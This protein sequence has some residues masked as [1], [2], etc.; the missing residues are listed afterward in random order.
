MIIAPQP[1]VT[2]RSVLAIAVPIMLSNVT[3]PLIGVVNT[4]VIGQLPQAYYI[5]AIAVGSL[6]F[7][8]IYWGFGFLRLGTGGVKPRIFP[9]PLLAPHHRHTL[10]LRTPPLR[11]TRMTCVRGTSVTPTAEACASSGPHSG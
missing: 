6:I 7:S 9:Y 3:E 2:R 8:F 5:G 1:V 4:T 11:S 10:W